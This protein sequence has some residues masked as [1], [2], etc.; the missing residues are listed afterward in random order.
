MV[1]PNKEQATIRGTKNTFVTFINSEAK[2]VLKKFM[3][4]R[5]ISED[6]RIFRKGFG[7]SGI[8]YRWHIASENSGVK[9]ISS[10]L[11]DWFCNELGKLGVADRYIDAICGRVPRSILGRHYTNYSPEILKEIY[12]NA[13]LTIVSD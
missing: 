8:T 6:S 9:L 4:S 10:D 12:E 11:P 5:E 7:K 13:N 3:A 1:I 2:T